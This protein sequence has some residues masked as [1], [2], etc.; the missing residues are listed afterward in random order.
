MEGAVCNSCLGKARQIVAKVSEFRELVGSASSS[1]TAPASR[2]T[3]SRAMTRKVPS[4]VHRPRPKIV[5][6]SVRPISNGK[7][8]KDC[9]HLLSLF[10]LEI[11]SFKEEPSKSC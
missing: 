9:S 7:N 10:N 2:V 4:S 3:A 1:A 5:N 6:L 8:K 11:K